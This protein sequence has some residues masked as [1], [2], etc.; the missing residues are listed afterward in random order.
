[1]FVTSVGGNWESS[2]EVSRYP[3]LGI[4]DLGEDVVGTFLQSFHWLFCVW[5]RALGIGGL[6]VLPDLFHVSFCRVHER[7]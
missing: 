3:F 4:D 1:M 2:G 6:D 5:G 7:R